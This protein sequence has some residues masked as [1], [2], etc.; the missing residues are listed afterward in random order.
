LYVCNNY[1]QLWAVSIDG[2]RPNWQPAVIYTVLSTMYMSSLANKIVVVVVL[3][4]LTACCFHPCICCEYQVSGQSETCQNLRKFSH[5]LTHPSPCLCYVSSSS[6][7][8]TWLRSHKKYPRVHT[9]T[10]CY[11]QPGL[12][13]SKL[14]A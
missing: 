8:R 9:R 7:K 14:K 11:I 12:Q 3:T 6:S 4:S 1:I 13:T 5:D 2:L 10:R